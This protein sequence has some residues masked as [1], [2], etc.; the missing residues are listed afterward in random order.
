ML[1]SN[2]RQHFE[3]LVGLRNSDWF[4][5]LVR[6]MVCMLKDSLLNIMEQFCS[7]R[8][9]W[10]WLFKVYWIEKMGV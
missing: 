8:T 4:N 3:S 5:K 7:K 9:E 10:L 2:L 6:K 1:L